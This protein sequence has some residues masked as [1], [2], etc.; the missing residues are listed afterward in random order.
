MEKDETLVK[1][2]LLQNLYS[3][4]KSMLI[5]FSPWLIASA[6]LGLALGVA[7]GGHA[8]RQM[9]RVAGEALASVI[10]LPQQVVNRGNKGDR[11]PLRAEV[12]KM[13]EDI[14]V[15]WDLEL[16]APGQFAPVCP[17]P[18]NIRWEPLTELV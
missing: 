16:S 8:E 11:L 3:M 1:Q 10:M 17:A 15:L 9:A 18:A 5:R 6:I 4:G 13:R 7:L 12:L 2:P 14:R